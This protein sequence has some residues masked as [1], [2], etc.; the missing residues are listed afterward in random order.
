MKFLIALLLLTSSAYGAV[1]DQE[2]L[3]RSVARVKSGGRVGTATVVDFGD[4]DSVYLLTCYHVVL[5]DSPT[6]Q[7]Y[8]KGFVSEPMKCTTVYK[9][10]SSS[11]KRDLAILQLDKKLLGDYEP[12]SVK[13]ADEGFK[14]S[15]QT[16]Y[17]IGHAHGAYPTMFEGRVVGVS[18]GIEF[19]PIPAQGRSGSS[20]ISKINGEYRIIGIIGWQTDTNGL[21]MDVTQIY[22]ILRGE[23]ISMPAANSLHYFYSEREIQYCDDGR[24]LPFS[25][26]FKKK[27]VNP[28]NPWL[29][30]PR[31]PPNKVPGPP[32][33][34][35][36][37]PEKE[38]API[39]APTF[40]WLDRIKK[41]EDEKSG[42][43][44]N[45][46]ALNQRLADLLKAAEQTSNELSKVKA[47]LGKVPSIDQL[48]ST[49]DS[50]VKEKIEGP[51]AAVD[52]FSNSV[53]EKMRVQDEK[54]L[55][56]DSR[57]QSAL[58]KIS[59]LSG[60]VA[61]IVGLIPGVGTATG[62]GLGL[63]SAI[64]GGIY[65][66]RRKKKRVP[67][68][69]ADVPG[70]PSPS[71]TQGP[72]NSIPFELVEKLLA[73]RGGTPQSTGVN[74]PKPGEPH[75]DI[76]YTLAPKDDDLLLLRQAMEKISQKYPPTGTTFKM[77]EQVFNLLKSGEK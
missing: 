22:K 70:V 62:L 2:D 38:N 65:S 42:L 5:E 34:V 44:S 21:A 27:D 29:K 26:L 71:P 37:S 77:V 31:S 6:V 66:L 49:V 41:L 57:S 24:C 61:P 68:P 73:L 72:T 54:L 52:D 14:T 4:S 67:Q 11:K 30:T 17:S 3:F 39:P 55:E 46:D 63:V 74:P 10:Y 19:E 36:E 13:L 23:E 47:D 16:I 35:P 58:K 43:N 69:P 25:N 59:E 64:A 20:L 33:I 56:Q 48:K 15:L 40:D 76:N 1:T 28:N 50:T 7:L 45:V 51:L 8:Q 18:T 12:A 75:Y 9:S 32:Q 53:N 60:T